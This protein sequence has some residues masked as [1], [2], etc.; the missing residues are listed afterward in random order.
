MPTPVL[1]QKI[2]VIVLDDIGKALINQ[3]YGELPYC[4]DPLTDGP[5]A[6]L[7]FPRFWSAPLCSPARASLLTG[8][9]AYRIG[10]RVGK[11]VTPG[12]DFYG[13]TGPWLT[14]GL[15]GSKVYF[16]KH[17]LSVLT[18]WPFMAG[19][20]K[21]DLFDGTINN[22]GPPPR[23]YYLWDRRQEIANVGINAWTETAY[24]TNVTASLAAQAMIA[25]KDLIWCAFNDVHEPLEN[26]PPQGQPAGAV[27]T[28][29]DL[30][31]LRLN[32]LK[33]LDWT[34]S[35]LRTIA[36]SCGYATLV[37]CDNGTPDAGKGTLTE[38]GI[39]TD[40]W[41]FGPGMNTGTCPELVSA[42]DLFATIRHLRGHQNPLEAAD[43]LSFAHLL[44][45]GVQAIN[46]NRAYLVRDAYD[47]LVDPP[48]A[49]NWRRAIRGPR[50]KLVDDPTEIEPLNRVRFYDLD[51]D[52]AE[53]QNLNLGSL[54]QEQQA[55][56]ADLWAHLPGLP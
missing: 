16:G 44:Y 48:T 7:Y 28:D 25:G 18:S 35:R 19:T 36:E 33:H 2:L 23:G 55:A 41:A 20:D 43:S 21:F 42:T 9:L 5:Y 10:N 13:P 17:H 37:I 31:H 4:F 22:L 30:D 3:H 45:P 38:A 32:H 12:T 51:A 53:Q 27:Y 15:P 50:W 1:D 6:S 40:A 52:P 29:G 34:L 47:D 11:N 46:P 8:T 54:T 39:C 14:A 26:L 56:Y 24:A 49:A